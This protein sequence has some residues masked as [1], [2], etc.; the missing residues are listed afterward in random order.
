MQK[1]AKEKQRWGQV[2]THSDTRERN[3]L[4]M[5]W[6]EEECTAPGQISYSCNETSFFLFLLLL[7]EFS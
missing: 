6:K 3:D 1:L 7:I 4:E 2:S 5:D